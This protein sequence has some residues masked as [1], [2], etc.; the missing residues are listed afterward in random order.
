MTD[1]NALE[2]EFKV[3][4][5]HFGGLVGLVKELKTKVENLEKNKEPDENVE[6]KK[7]VEK[8]Q[9]KI[10]ELENK[11]AEKDMD[12]IESIRENQRIIDKAIAANSAAI[13]KIDK[14]IQTAAKV[15]E[16]ANNED[17]NEV[18]KPKKC[19]YNNCGFC[20]YKTKCRYTHS[21][22]ICKS[23]A[24]NQRC[25]IKDC[26]DRHPVVCKW[27]NKKGGC[28]RNSECD[29]LHV[30]LSSETEMNQ[31]YE[32]VSCRCVWTDKTCVKE[33]IVQNMKKYF[34]LNCDDWVKNKG[35]VLQPGWTLLDEAGCPRMDI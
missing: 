23:H 35:N 33:H 27:F 32:C 9:S 6:I 10:E 24:L 3:M 20:K 4:K 13:S 16:D 5:K 29:Y 14:E 11:I 31:S 1:K 34:C 15:T 28:K 22:H 2:E 21:K 30:Q 19:R 26:G 12:L 18:I 7:I 17:Q 8:Q 25:E